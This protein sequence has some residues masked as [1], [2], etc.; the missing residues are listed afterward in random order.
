MSSEL[1]KGDWLRAQIDG[2]PQEDASG[3]VPVP[4]FQLWALLVMSKQLP[5][6]VGLAAVFVLSFLVMHWIYGYVIAFQSETNDCFFIFGRAFFLEFL[7]HPAGPLRY[8]GRFL[9]QLYHYRWLGALIVAACITC[10][11]AL[12]HRVLAKL[13]GTVPVSQM[14]LPCLLLLALHTSTLYLAYDTLGLCASCG[15]FLGYLSLRARL[16]RCIYALAATPIL[17]LLLGFYAWF[18][19]AWIVAFE[20]LD[21]PLRSGL[22]FKIGYLVFA[23][24]VPLIAWRWVFLIPLPSALSCPIIFEPPFRTGSPDQSFAYFVVDCTLAVVLYGLLLLVPFWGRLFSGTGFATF[25][26]IKPDRW[27]R[28]CLV[29]AIPLFAILLHW[30]RYDAPLAT[31]VACRQLYK[32]KQ[33]DALLEKAKRNP[34]G[35]LRVQFMTNFALYHKGRL[36]EEMFSYP[37]PWGTRGLFLNFSGKPVASPAE[38]DTDDGMYNSDLLYEMGHANYSLIH[39]YNCMCLEGRTYETMERMAQCSMLNGQY[40]MAM[41]YLNL[42]ER[43]LFHRR[44]ARRYKAI[45]ADP[46]AAEREFGELRTRLPVQDGFGHPLVHFATLLNAK[47]DNRMALDYLMAWLLLDKKQD[48]IDSIGASIGQFRIAG[49]ASIPTC[50]QEA[51]L[52]KERAERAPVDLQGFRYDPAT[53][54]RVDRFLQDVSQHWGQGDAIEHARARYGDTYMY[55]YL[56]VTTP[57]DAPQISG[58]REGLGGTGLQE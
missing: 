32:Q 2:T 28:A 50:C 8:A 38:D 41:K 13:D 40:E 9:G 17:Y 31:V 53:V 6:F 24:A 34:Y 21:R 27:S 11:G 25:W 5:L 20:W 49:Y 4:L 57:S 48:S 18:F 10:F 52:L 29:I 35:D 3:E 36:L 14:L 1:K 51:L 37:Q 26:R 56:F 55:Y 54:A 58:S 30:I 43:T 19:V 42:L 47:Q 46:V 22:V 39:A 15:A 7:D 33:W 45:L 16:A 12:F 44:F 23:L